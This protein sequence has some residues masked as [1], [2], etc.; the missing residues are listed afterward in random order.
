MGLFL[1]LATVLIVHEVA[2][3]MN[4]LTGGAD[5]LQGIRMAPVL[6]RFAFDLYGRVA[7]GYAAVVLALG[8][9]ALTLMACQSIATPAESAPPLPAPAV[10]TPAGPATSAIAVFAGGCFWGIQGVF[11]HVA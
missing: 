10:D 6:G 11:Q 5:G 4:W 2:N 1:S 3:R 8:F 9:L 7:Y